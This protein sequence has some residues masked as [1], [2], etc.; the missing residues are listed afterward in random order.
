M[1]MTPVRVFCMFFFFSFFGLDRLY[2]R[3]LETFLRLSTIRE[4]PNKN[5]LLWEGDGA[6]LAH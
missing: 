3:R 5:L 1:V 2:D 6:D 4:L